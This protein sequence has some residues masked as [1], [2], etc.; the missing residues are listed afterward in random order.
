MSPVRYE[1]GIYIPEDEILHIYFSPFLL[2]CMCLA[3]SSAS[4]QTG[5]R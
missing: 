4:L 3:T 2:L 5:L 1:M